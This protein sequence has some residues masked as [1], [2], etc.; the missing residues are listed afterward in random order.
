MNDLIKKIQIL[1]MSEVGYGEK[2]SAKKIQF[3]YL[4]GELPIRHKGKYTYISRAI[5]SPEG[6]L[7][8]FKYNKQIIGSGI[9]ESKNN[10]NKYLQFAP[11]TLEIYNPPIETNELQK[12]WTDY[13]ESGRV[14][15][16]LDISKHNYFNELYQRRK[17]GVFEQEEAFQHLINQSIEG[18]T[19]EILDVPKEKIR[20]NSQTTSYYI[21]D[22][23]TS[24][25]AIL[26][27]NFTCEINP[28][29][30]SFISKITQENFVEAHHLVPISYYD[31][32]N[33][34]I[35]IEANIISLCPNCHKKI[36]Y[37]LQKEKEG[38][39]KELWSRR[40]TRLQKVGINIAFERLFSYYQ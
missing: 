40:I 28:E 12:V 20:K 32:F 25:N 11:Q 27:S 38:M 5:S 14:A 16:I 35:D 30:K 26:N 13:R 19:R 36:H 18:E 1:P 7:I 23:K 3:E 9:L 21:R 22:I 24:R 10:E 17:I 37:G 31:D 4:L 29:H 34:S 15:K 2:T 39:L 33:K 6:T 8:L